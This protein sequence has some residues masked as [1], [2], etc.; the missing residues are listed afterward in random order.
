MANCLIDELAEDIA[1][2]C[3]F[4][5]IPGLEEDI[6]LIAHDKVDKSASAINSTNPNILDDLV[7]KEGATGYALEGVKQTNSFNHEFVKGDQQT[8]NKHRHFINGRIL[9]PNAVNRNNYDILATGKPYL[10][11]VHKKYK[12][13]NAEDAFLV[14]GWDAGITLS[15]GSESSTENDGAILLQMSSEDEMLENKSPK[16][17]LIGDYETTLAAFNNRFV[18]KI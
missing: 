4:L 13:E 15:E 9:S 17:L 5:A 16:T 11:V 1:I 10:A 8:L 18:Q 7:L 3:D 6:V 14:L 2:D 12:G